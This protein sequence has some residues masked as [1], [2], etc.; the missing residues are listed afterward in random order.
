MKASFEDMVRAV[1]N[2]AIIHRKRI[3]I[4]FVGINL[5]VLLLGLIWPKTYISSTTILVDEKNIIQPLMQGA[6]VTTD[7]SER[8]RMAREVIYGR[9]IMGQVLDHAGWL[10]DK[11]S[12][13][14][15]EWRIEQL[16]KQT[17]VSLVGRNLIKIQYR[18]DSPQRAYET[19]KMMG[20]LFVSESTNTKTAE[21]QAAYEFIEQQVKE[22][23]EKLTQAEEQLKEF[24]SQNLDTR[25][26]TDGEVSAR[27]RDL[28]NR[29]EQT[30]L[31][32]K[33]AKIKQ[34]SLEKQLS[35]E[36]ESTIAFSREGQYRTR[37]AELQS[38]L[39]TL[40]LSYKENHPDVAHI[41]HQIEDLTQAIGNE[42][43]ARANRPPG[44]INDE[45][46]SLNPIYQ[47]LKRD[48]GQT[49]VV[50]DT[51]TTRLEENKRLLERERERG[52][53]VHGGEATLAELTR[54]YEVNRDIYH[55]LLRRREN[56]RVSMNLDREQQGLTFKISEPAILQLQPSGLRLGHF[57][58]GGIVLGL[59]L[60]VG[61]L[62]GMQ[63]IDAKIRFDSIISERLK[64]PVVASIPHFAAHAEALALDTD[65]RWIAKL[66][67]ANVAVLAAVLAL[68]VTGML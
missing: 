31:E 38:Q 55:D 54:D 16:K 37:I 1:M 39:E 32:L 4:A 60:P 34:A 15:Q 42:R 3:A 45:V 14:E 12:A 40:R 61:F 68:R 11:P 64:L 25:P 51:L 46:I 35:G 50:I 44:P 2:E 30:T 18:D 24:R 56:A 57:L 52:M 26:G 13:V 59:L 19:A 10:S 21:S 6:A 49:K 8:A 65:V 66:L 7:V 58:L 53:R 62:Y 23:H 27:I 48:L 47:Q 67:A 63:Q 28:Q 17:T 33:E 43:R 5:T 9:K 41:K 29:I 22:Y 36:A 20:D